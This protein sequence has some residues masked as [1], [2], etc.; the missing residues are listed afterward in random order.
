MTKKIRLYQPFGDLGCQRPEKDS[1]HSR[2]GRSEDRL[3]AGEGAVTQNAHTGLAERAKL[4]AYLENIGCKICAADLYSGAVL[5]I[6]QSRCRRIILRKM[7]E[8]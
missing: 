4:P 5:F 1:L 7:I 8:K 2:D 6:H 3:H